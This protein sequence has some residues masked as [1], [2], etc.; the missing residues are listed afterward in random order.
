MADSRRAAFNQFRYI[1]VVACVLLVVLRLSIGWQF[2]YEGLWKY[3]TL[4]TTQPWTAEGYLKNAQGP[5]RELFR[6]GMTDDP[7][8]LGWLNEEAVAARWDAW[9]TQFADHY[10][11]DDDQRARLDTMVNGPQEFR[12]VLTAMPEGVEI[13]GRLRDILRF[14]ARAERLILKGDTPLMPAEKESLLALAV[15]PAEVTDANRAEAALVD[16]FRSAVIRLAEL[17]ERFSYK[18]K[19][20]LA[21]GPGDPDR[22]RHMFANFK[23]TIG[24]KAPEEIDDYYQ[25]LLKDYQAKL[26]R[27]DVAFQREH[28]DRQWSKIQELRNEL[29]GPV[30]ALDTALKSDAQT[31]LTR[32][33]IERG[34]LPKP[35]TTQRVVDAMTIAALMVLGLMLLVGLGTRAAAIMGAGMVLSFYLVWPPW[36]GVPLDPTPE[37]AY[38]VNKNFIE[39]VALLAL[40]ALPTGQWFGLDRLIYRGWLALRGRRS[41][42]P[43]TS[44]TSEPTVATSTG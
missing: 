18:Q 29:T 38:I 37:H 6:E 26:E 7:D 5:F 15:E 25:S 12:A 1:P 34:P 10:G 9:Q 24:E 23:G 2:L 27:A 20:R 17:S 21:L 13:P 22:V 42:P 16:E 35:W 39:I 43:K 40:A 28:L 32:E 19:L 14:D 36:P 4:D 33:Q 30:K 8:E 3:D 31:L 11:L 44:T 41:S